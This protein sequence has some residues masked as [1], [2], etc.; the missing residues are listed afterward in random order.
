MSSHAA[1]ASAP[2]SAGPELV[3]FAAILLFLLEVYKNGTGYYK[4]CN[5]LL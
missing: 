3:L 1:S 5:A 4:Q 2:V